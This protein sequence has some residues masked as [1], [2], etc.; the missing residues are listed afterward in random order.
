MKHKLADPLII[1]LSVIPKLVPQFGDIE[2]DIKRFGTSTV[3]L[4]EVS[5]KQT[6]P[7]IA[8]LQESD[9]VLH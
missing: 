2:P 7:I 3:K 4:F 6:P 5:V 8:E 9:N 1:I